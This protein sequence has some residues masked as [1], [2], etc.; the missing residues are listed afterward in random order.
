M[1]LSSTS[2]TF[3]FVVLLFHM[4]KLL[5]TW[6]NKTIDGG[7]KFL[8]NLSQTDCSS[9]WLFSDV[10]TRTYT[11]THIYRHICKHIHQT[12]V[13]LTCKNVWEIIEKMYSIHNSERPVYSSAKRVSKLLS[14]HQYRKYCIYFHIWEGIWS[15]PDLI[16]AAKIIF[17]IQNENT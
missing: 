7:S 13:C 14:F 5:L 11:H 1:L 10:P 17:L 15:R 12:Q 3:V 16:Q 6:H 8:H 9:S 2:L 4:I